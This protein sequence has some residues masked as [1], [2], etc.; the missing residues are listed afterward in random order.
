MKHFL[1]LMLFLTQTI[2]AGYFKE[3][4]KGWHWYQAEPG[5]ISKDISQPKPETVNHGDPGGINKIEYSNPITAKQKL[6]RIREELEE[7]LSLAILHPTP[8]HIQ[9]FQRMQQRWVNRSEEFSSQWMKNLIE[10]PSLDATARSP[11]S[12]F[13][14]RVRRE[15]EQQ[16]MEDK[17]RP[18]TKTHGLFFFYQGKCKYCQAMAPIIK[19]LSDKYGWKVIG[20]TQDG[21]FLPEFPGSKKDNG[22]AEAWGIQWVPAVFVVQPETEIVK[23]ISYGVGSL[24]QVEKN[25]VRQLDDNGDEK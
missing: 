9:S 14:V 11:T 1:T 22:I 20:V 4:S 16:Q 2:Q 7:A 6:Q 12:H 15:L 10:Y 18:Y 5:P 19:M 24:E 25:L 17:I 3:K 23:P 8:S 21:M 13:G